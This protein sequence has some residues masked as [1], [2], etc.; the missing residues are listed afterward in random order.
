MEFVPQID[1]HQNPE[2][3]D[4]QAKDEV[5]GKQDLFHTTE[6][7]NFLK[8]NDTTLVVQTTLVVIFSIPT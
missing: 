8:G 5:D 6:D 7:K 2:H 3:S 1:G 4:G